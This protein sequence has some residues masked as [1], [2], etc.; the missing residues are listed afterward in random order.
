MAQIQLTVRQFQFLPHE[1]KQSVKQTNLL[2]SLSF[3]Q[4]VLYFKF[5]ASHVLSEVLVIFQLLV[6]QAVQI[7]SFLLDFICLI[8]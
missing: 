7:F 3:L 2:F 6:N 5:F 4:K 1:M 8:L